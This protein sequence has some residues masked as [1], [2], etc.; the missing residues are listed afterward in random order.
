MST[1]SEFHDNSR[2]KET[3]TD[4]V[5]MVARLATYGSRILAMLP[6]VGQAAAYTNWRGATVGTI[7]RFKEGPRGSPAGGSTSVLGGPGFHSCVRASNQKVQ[8]QW[9]CCLVFHPARGTA[10]DVQSATT[11]V[12][13]EE[14]LLRLQR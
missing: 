1:D 5:N 7:L 14:S 3:F 12:V 2:P 11:I 8:I 13:G 9:C 4:D 10:L 6:H